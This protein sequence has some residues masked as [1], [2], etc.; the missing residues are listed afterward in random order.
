MIIVKA[1]HLGGRDQLVSAYI[2][3]KEAEY[4]AYF[5]LGMVASLGGKNDGTNKVKGMPAIVQSRIN[6]SNNGWKH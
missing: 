6:I 3:A 4:I 1:L 2:E 5:A